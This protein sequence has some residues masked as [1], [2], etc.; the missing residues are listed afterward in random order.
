MERDGHCPIAA[1]MQDP[2]FVDLRGPGWAE[3]D[4]LVS[5]ELPHDAAMYLYP[6]SAM[7]QTQT[8]PRCPVSRS[9]TLR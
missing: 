7:S 5:A 3:D 8:V 4:T 1:L 2:R 6:Q 9:S